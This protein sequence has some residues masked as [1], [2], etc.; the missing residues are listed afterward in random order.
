VAI[1]TAVDRELEGRDLRARDVLAAALAEAGRT[2]EAAAIVRAIADAVEARSG[3]AAAANW[4]AAA[5]RY[6]RGEPM[7]SP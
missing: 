1:A 4:R 5:A 6:E 2:A 7:R 3:A